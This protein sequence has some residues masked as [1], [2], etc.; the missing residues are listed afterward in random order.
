MTIA[1]DLTILLNKLELLREQKE[2]LQ[3]LVE[4]QNLFLQE[5]QKELKE[6]ERELQ[7]TQKEL[8]ETERELQETQ[9]ELKETERELQETQKELKE[10]ERELQQTHNLYKVLAEGIFI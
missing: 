8:K 2:F 3:N 5:T 6:T 9:K 1:Q 10:T 4:G 7:E